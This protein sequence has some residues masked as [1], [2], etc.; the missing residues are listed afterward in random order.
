MSVVVAT[1]VQR[2]KRRNNSE[3][4]CCFL[5]FAIEQIGNPSHYYYYCW[6]IH[7]V[8]SLLLKSCSWWETCCRW[9]VVEE[10]QNSI[11]FYSR[12]WVWIEDLDAKIVVWCC[13]INFLALLPR[14]GL[15]RKDRTKLQAGYEHKYF[16]VPY[17]PKLYSQHLKSQHSTKW[18]EYRSLSLDAKRIFFD[19]TALVNTMH[20]H[21]VGS[22]D[23]CILI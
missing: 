20:A 6:R 14:M 19:A 8:H 2:C 23:N 16:K 15:W 18:T 13:H 7:D 5:F 10:A 11:Q 3:E 12:T 1:I 9:N 21:F 17:R 22:G 4:F